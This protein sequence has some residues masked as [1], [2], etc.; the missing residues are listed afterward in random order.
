MGMIMGMIMVITGTITAITN[1]CD[2]NGVGGLPHAPLA[3]RA[4]AAERAAERA[5]DTDK[6]AA[7]VEALRA[8]RATRLVP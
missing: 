2:F 8:P 6:V 1:R 7:E 4:E 3:L 5:T